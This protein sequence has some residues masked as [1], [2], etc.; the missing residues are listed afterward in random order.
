MPKLHKAGKLVYFLWRKGA[1]GCGVCGGEATAV[2]ALEL[3]QQLHAHKENLLK[4]RDSR[5]YWM[6]LGAQDICS[7]ASLWLCGLLRAGRCGAE[8]GGGGG[9]GRP[10][11]RAEAGCRCAGFQCVVSEI[12][13]EMA[14]TFSLN[15][16][17]RK[18]P[19]QYSNLVNHLSENF[20]DHLS[21]VTPSVLFPPTVARNRG[22]PLFTAQPVTFCEHRYCEGRGSSRSDKDQGEQA[23]KFS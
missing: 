3:R 11:A 5:H 1:E 13:S 8:A 7:L 15:D 16:S 2:L 22:F 23:Q 20:G 21:E 10:R 19:R 14:V 9:A 6:T 12:N 17:P 4:G 18:S